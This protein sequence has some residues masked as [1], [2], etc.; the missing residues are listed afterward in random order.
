MMTNRRR[1]WRRVFTCSTAT[2]TNIP[3]T[4]ATT[5]L[6]NHTAATQNTT[7]PTTTA[8]NPTGRRG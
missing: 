5:R 1:Y 8:T 2:P 6:S 7:I 3:T 4:K